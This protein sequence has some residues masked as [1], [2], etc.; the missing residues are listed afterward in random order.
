[1]KRRGDRCGNAAQSHNKHMMKTLVTILMMLVLT[2]ANASAE[3][4]KPPADYKTIATRY[5]RNVLKDPDSAKIS[6]ESVERWTAGSIPVR[7]TDTP[8]NP[9]WAV[10]AFVNAKNSF[11]GY[12]GTHKMIVYLDN[13]KAV[14]V[15]DLSRGY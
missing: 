12:T 5:I 6:I 10:V 7:G 13:G 14:N 15:T 1:M 8:V 11:G 3:C 9:C 4:G 2:V